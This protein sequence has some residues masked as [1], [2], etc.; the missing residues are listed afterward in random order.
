[1]NEGSSDDAAS[2]GERVVRLLVLVDADVTVPS[3]AVLPACRLEVTPSNVTLTVTYQCAG[4]PLPR[5]ALARPARTGPAR[6][7]PAGNNPSAVVS[8]QTHGHTEW[9][10]VR[11]KMT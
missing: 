2:L 6:P 8:K 9:E 5:R 11:K 7:S 4:G 1:M 10:R 3:A